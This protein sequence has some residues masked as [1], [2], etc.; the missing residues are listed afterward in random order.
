MK[1]TSK[2]ITELYVDVSCKE[3]VDNLA[4]HINED[5]D[6]I[7]DDA[8]HNLKDILLALPILFRKLKQNGLIRHVISKV[9]NKGQH[10]IT[11][12]FEY[13]NQDSF[14][15]CES[16]LNDAF[17]PENCPVLAKFVFKIFNNSRII[18][19]IKIHYIYRILNF[20]IYFIFGSL[21]KERR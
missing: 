9:W 15:K 2:R 4:N 10:R 1:Y 13:E 5:L 7:I 20:F 12:V 19:K 6:L 3:I 17:T 21:S 11:Q 8:S 16:I 18:T 14:K